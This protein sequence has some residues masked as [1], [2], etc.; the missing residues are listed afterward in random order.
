VR[1]ARPTP[2]RA[3]SKPRAAINDP[4]SRCLARCLK[5]GVCPR[6]ASVR[7]TKGAS[8]APASSISTSCAPAA[9][10][11]YLDPVVG[12]PVLDLGW[13]AFAGLLV[14]LLG[15]NAPLRQPGADVVGVEAD[16]E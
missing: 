2:V 6:R 5:M 7:R 12:Q 1:K 9:T 11:F 8:S 3:T 4:F 15:S 16:A 14:G 13:I 10:F